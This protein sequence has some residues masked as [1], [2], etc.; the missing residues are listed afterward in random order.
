MPEKSNTKTNDSAE[1][2][3]AV[4]LH[5]VGFTNVP[6]E[7]EERPVFITRAEQTTRPKRL[8]HLCKKVFFWIFGVLMLL[9]M[10]FIAFGILYSG[11]RYHG[12]SWHDIPQCTT[13]FGSIVGMHNGVVA[14][15]NCN[16]NHTS[17]DFSTVD[18]NQGASDKIFGMK[19]QCVEY[20][21]RY[22]MLRGTPLPARFDS[23]AG[24]ADIWALT[25]AHLLNGTSVP[26]AKITNGRPPAPGTD[27]RPRVGDLLIYPQRPEDFPHGHVAVI[28]E[29]TAE[30]VL[31][32][33]QNWD[34][35]VWPAPHHNYSRAIPLSCTAAPSVCTIT[36][37]DD[38]AVQG[39]VRYVV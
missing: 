34:N 14:Y 18:G 30:N 26:L 28:V 23:V 39:W 27:A 9:F 37:A 1:D 8:R 5:E 38:V 10:T 7:G 16:I 24:A 35:A 31:V 12:E 11:I 36:E 17:S 20:A 3:D 29:V 33:E 4:C 22:W 6:V 19:W 25:E 32:A 13:T 15:S 21:R 2:D